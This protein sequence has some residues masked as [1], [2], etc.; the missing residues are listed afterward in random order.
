MRKSRIIG[1]VVVLV[2]LLTC[3]IHEPSSLA[4][5]TLGEWIEDTLQQHV[6][7]SA[8]RRRLENLTIAMVELSMAS[9]YYS[10]VDWSMTLDSRTKEVEVLGSL[11]LYDAG[12]NACMRQVQS[13]EVE[14]AVA[15]LE[16]IAK[17]VILEII[18][19]RLLL[20]RN[21][22]KSECI[23]RGMIALRD[24][25]GEKRLLMELQ[26]QL[27][28]IAYESRSLR[29]QLSKSTD[30]LQDQSDITSLVWPELELDREAAVELIRMNPTICAAYRMYDIDCR[31]QDLLS[32]VPDTVKITAQLSARA[33]PDQPLQTRFA[34]LATIPLGDSKWTMGTCS[35][36]T[37]G[38]E[39]ST[40]ARL[41]KR[42]SLLYDFFEGTDWTRESATTALSDYIFTLEQS[43]DMLHLSEMQL[44]LIRGRMPDLSIA[45]SL[46]EYDRTSL[47]SDWISAALAEAEAEYRYASSLFKILLLTGTFDQAFQRAIGGIIGLP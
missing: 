41:S 15:E 12:R 37:D 9:Y 11:S 1:F 42:R 34:V 18:D 32:S 24:T 22:R 38:N 3:P 4:S 25:Y 6:S 36:E 23:R 10:P 28:L 29:Y 13:L 26:L 21:Q 43:F 14:R 33:K 16:S 2:L 5:K 46:G 44:W 17:S 31:M 35:V 39:H 19:T 30:D 45:D 27:D 7:N 20:Q 47:V 8:Y 40:Y